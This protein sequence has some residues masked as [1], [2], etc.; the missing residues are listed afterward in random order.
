MTTFT[1]LSQYQAMAA[2]R[3]QSTRNLFRTLLGLIW[4]AFVFLGCIKSAPG[5]DCRVWG[6]CVW[7]SP[8]G[9]RV[10]GFRLT[11]L[12]FDIRVSGWPVWFRVQGFGIMSSGSGVRVQ[13]SGLRVQGCGCRVQGFGVPAIHLP[14]NR[15]AYHLHEHLVA[16]F[17]ADGSGLTIQGSGFCVS[18]LGLQGLCL[19]SSVPD[20]LFRVSRIS[21]F[22]FRILHSTFQTSC[23]AF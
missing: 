11:V 18:C 23:I 2:L 7:I 1:A 19:I 13:G 4:P 17:S 20:S 5:E 12:G 15:R 6:F 3:L 22:G 8:L 14:S 16:G 21:G 9:F 10:Q